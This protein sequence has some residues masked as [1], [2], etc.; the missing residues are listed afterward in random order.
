[1][2]LFNRFVPTHINNYKQTYQEMIIVAS[3]NVI[4]LYKSLKKNKKK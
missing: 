2:N 1:M 3:M 4:F